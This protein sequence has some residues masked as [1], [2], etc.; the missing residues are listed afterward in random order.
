MKAR[1]SFA[2]PAGSARG[3]EIVAR[4]AASSTSVASASTVVPSART[5][6]AAEIDSSAA[7][8]WMTSVAS[9]TASVMV[10]VPAKVNEEKL[11]SKVRS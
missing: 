5:A 2:S 1:T 3:N 11:G 4:S 8:S 6:E 7:W 10:A 9:A